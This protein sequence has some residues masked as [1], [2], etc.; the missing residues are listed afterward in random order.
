M[1]KRKEKGKEK[2]EEWQRREHKGTIKRK[3]C[4]VCPPHSRECLG[5]ELKRNRVQDGANP[6]TQTKDKVDKAGTK[7]SIIL[8]TANPWKGELCTTKA[9]TGKNLKQECDKRSLVYETSCHDAATE[10]L[11]T[12]CPCDPVPS[13]RVPNETEC[14][15]GPVPTGHRGPRDPKSIQ[16][17]PKGGRKLLPPVRW[18]L[19][20]KFGLKKD[21][22]MG[23]G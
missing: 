19:K 8:T 11:A 17:K 1:P 7:I 5:Q 21:F 14:P 10:C 15:W 22:K 16:I 2:R 23:L 13:N 9:W 20:R 18:S 4:N 3:S 6:W 12:E